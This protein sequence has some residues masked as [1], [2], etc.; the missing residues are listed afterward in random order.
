MGVVVEVETP[1]LT[2]EFIG[3]THRVLEA[4]QT[5]PPRN[6]HQKGPIGLWVAEEVTE[7]QPRAQQAASFPSVGLSP[8]YSSVM[9]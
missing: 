3:E 2:G 9:Q 5:H 6:Q 4:T 8:T 1:S 7:S